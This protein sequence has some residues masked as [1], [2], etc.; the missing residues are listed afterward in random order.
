MYVDECD[1]GGDRDAGGV[2]ETPTD[3]AK[4]AEQTTPKKELTPAK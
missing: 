3:T 4:S 2:T 1:V